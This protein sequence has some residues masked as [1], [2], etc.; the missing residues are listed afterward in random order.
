[1]PNNAPPTSFDSTR[2]TTSAW[3]IPPLRSFGP[4]SSKNVFSER[5]FLGCDTRDWGQLGRGP[6]CPVLLV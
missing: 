6:C 2:I 5:D 4:A 3:I 1:V